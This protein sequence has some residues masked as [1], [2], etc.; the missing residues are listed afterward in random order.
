MN[1]INK[2]PEQIFKNKTYFYLTCYFL[3][4]ARFS[5]IVDS[6]QLD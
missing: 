6:Y 5:A 3:K 2:T 1:E 4:L